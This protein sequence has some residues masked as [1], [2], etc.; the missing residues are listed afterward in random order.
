MRGGAWLAVVA[1]ALAAAGCADPFF[2]SVSVLE[3]TR[4]TGGPYQVW[5]VAVGIA[6]GDRVELYYNVV[7][8]QPGNFIPLR[9]DAADD[10][11]GAQESELY[12]R[13][14][15]GQ[16]AA[17]DIRYYVA[18]TRDGEQVAASPVGGDLRPFVF[19]VLP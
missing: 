12:V 4:D 6:A 19:T 13:G 15:P 7:D 10:H 9:M 11:D 16:A 2:E 5:A 3:D 14:I 18:I 17:T 8:D 1:A